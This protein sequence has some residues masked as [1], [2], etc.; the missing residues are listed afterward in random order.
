MCRKWLT[1]GMTF[2]LLL[3]RNGN[4]NLLRCQWFLQNTASRD[5]E[6]CRG[7]WQWYGRRKALTLGTEDH[8]LKFSQLKKHLSQLLIQLFIVSYKRFVIG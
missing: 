5:V 2:I 1:A 3:N 8:A 6:K 4:S 7:G